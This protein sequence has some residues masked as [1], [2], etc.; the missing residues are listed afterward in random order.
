M[1]SLF[2]YNLFTSVP[3][4]LYSLYIPIIRMRTASIILYKTRTCVHKL[5]LNLAAWKSDH[6][7]VRNAPVHIWRESSSIPASD[8]P[9]VRVIYPR[10]RRGKQSTTTHKQA[11]STTQGWQAESEGSPRIIR[12]AAGYTT[13]DT[14]YTT[15]LQPVWCE[16]QIFRHVDT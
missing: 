12:T 15:F 5:Y 3:L 11:H 1:C 16:T 13:L 6:I 8:K 14:S 9:N 7:H 4:A 10:H 2:I